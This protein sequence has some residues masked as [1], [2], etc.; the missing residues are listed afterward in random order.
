MLHRG[1]AEWDDF[2]PSAKEAAGV[3]QTVSL[4]EPSRQWTARLDFTGTHLG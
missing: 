2:V 4:T 1:P 3:K